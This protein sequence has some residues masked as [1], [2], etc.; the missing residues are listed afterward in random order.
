MP[1]RGAQGSTWDDWV[2]GTVQQQH[3]RERGGEGRGGNT[4]P[5]HSHDARRQ[6]S[7]A[8]RGTRN[9]LCGA[10]GGRRWIDDGWMEGGEERRGEER[11]SKEE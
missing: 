4:R 9:V 2:E 8:R 11:R 1:I 7:E 6:P 10:A 5:P 3:L